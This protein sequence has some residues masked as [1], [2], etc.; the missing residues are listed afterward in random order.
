MTSVRLFTPRPFV[1][2]WVFR[3]LVL[4]S[5][6]VCLSSPWAVTTQARHLPIWH[7]STTGNSRF[8]D[9]SL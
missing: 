3:S 7:L 2:V 4:F 9:L 8:T 5:K 6:R 1:H